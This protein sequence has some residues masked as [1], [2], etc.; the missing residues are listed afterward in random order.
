[1]NAS[2]PS[3]AHRL[4]PEALYPILD[5]APSFGQYI[6]GHSSTD[7]DPSSRVYTGVND[8]TLLGW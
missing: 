7:S 3:F 2:I 5:P 4:S 1:M 6:A 8:G